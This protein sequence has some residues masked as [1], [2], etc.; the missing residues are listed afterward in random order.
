MTSPDVEMG[1]FQ[2]IRQ[3]HDGAL[4]INLRLS[5]TTVRHELDSDPPE[6]E[7]TYGLDEI[8][9]PGNATLSWTGKDAWQATP[10]DEV[11][12]AYRVDSGQWSPFTG[13]KSHVFETLDSGGH[14]FEVKSRDRA[15]NEDPTPARI[16]FT[17]QAPVWQQPWA[18]TLTIVFISIISAT[19]RPDRPQGSPS[20]PIARRPRRSDRNYGLGR[21]F[22]PRC[23]E[24]ELAW[25]LKADLP[26]GRVRG[27]GVKLRQVLINLLGNAVKFTEAGTITLTVAAQED[28]V[29]AFA[30]DDTGPGVPEEKQASIFEPFQQEEQGM[31]QGGTGL[32]LDEIGD[33]P[34]DLQA[35][36]LRVLE[37]RAVMA[38]GGSKERAVDVHVLSATHQDLQAAVREGCFRQDLYYRLAGSRLACRLCASARMISRCW[39]SIFCSCW[40]TKW[41][42][43]WQTSRTRRWSR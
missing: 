6:T 40:P 16:A 26:E 36:L 14:T 25:I 32:G 10:N 42:S 7:I 17:V 18:A 23:A 30:I 33:M 2:S 35:K 34:L 22:E 15:F 37:E 24:K 41:A 43:G 8:P 38:V 39:R 9:Q 12:F 31:R 20:E 1:G 3:T 4:W 29:Y 5:G 28:E 11:L 27:D 13:E 19:D 21:M